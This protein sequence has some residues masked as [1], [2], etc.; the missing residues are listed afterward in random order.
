MEQDALSDVDLN[1]FNAGMEN[2]KNSDNKR[3]K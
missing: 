3:D 1:S 2:W